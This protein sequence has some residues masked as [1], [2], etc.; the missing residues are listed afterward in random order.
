[1]RPAARAG[2]RGIVQTIC[3]AARPNSRRHGM[4]ILALD[5]GKDKTIACDYQSDSAEHRPL[6]VRTSPAE[7]R[8]LIAKCRPGRVVLEACPAAGWALT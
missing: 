4:K 7:L 2:M 3:Y 8:A 1:L 6:A 5:L